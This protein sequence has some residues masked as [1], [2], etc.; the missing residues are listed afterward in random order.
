LV[1]PPPGITLATTAE[2]NRITLRFSADNRAKPGPLGNLIVEVAARP[3]RAP[4]GAAAK[5]FKIGTLPPIPC[6]ITAGGG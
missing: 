2:P 3:P 5:P 4:K 6:R 1:N